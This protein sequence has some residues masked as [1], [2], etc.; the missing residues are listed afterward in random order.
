M[1]NADPPTT[2]TTVTGQRSSSNADTAVAAAGA[3]IALES[4][5]GSAAVER[6]LLY[7]VRLLDEIAGRE[8]VLLLCGGGWGGWL[9]WGRFSMLGEMHSL[10]P[11]R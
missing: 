8:Y 9:S 2:A 5:V 4:N 7:F 1:V 6:L 3:A 10:L 11:R